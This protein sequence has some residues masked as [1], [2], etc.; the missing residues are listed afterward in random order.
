MNG[1]GRKLNIIQQTTCKCNK[2]DKLYCT[3]HRLP[4]YHNCCYNYKVRSDEEIKRFIEKTNV[5]IKK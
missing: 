2:C 3:K 5:L 1:C 4:E